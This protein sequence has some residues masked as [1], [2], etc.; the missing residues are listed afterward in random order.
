MSRYLGG[1]LCLP[2]NGQFTRSLT[3]EIGSAI[4]ETLIAAAG[5]ITSIESSRQHVSRQERSQL[6]VEAQRCNSTRRDDTE[7]SKVSGNLT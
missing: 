2:S 7:P 6:V 4:A 3:K 5:S 1:L